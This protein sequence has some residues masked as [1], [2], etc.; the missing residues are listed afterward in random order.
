MSGLGS[1]IQAP[2]TALLQGA[3][4]STTSS[5]AKT[6]DAKKREDAAKAGREFEAILVRQMLAQTKIAGKSGGY[7][8]MAVEALA[9]SVTQAGGLGMGRAIEDALAGHSASASASLPTPTP[10]SAEA[11]TTTITPKESASIAKKTGPIPLPQ[12]K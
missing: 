8:D 10:T 11:A 4:A 5:T 9:T 2:S 6:G 1:K 12:K 3:Q 7:G